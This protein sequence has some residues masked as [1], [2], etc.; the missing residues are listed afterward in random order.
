M[1]VK[2]GK[3]QS[4][5][6][7]WKLLVPLLLFTFYSVWLF[8][9][10]KRSASD[11][12]VE[13][14]QTYKK[15]QDKLDQ[16]REEKKS[17]L[18]RSAILE[19]SSQVDRQ[20]NIGVRNEV[21]ALQDELHEARKELELYRGIISPGDVKPGLR[22]QRLEI[23]TTQEEGLYAFELTLTQV[24]RSGRSAQG[25]IGLEVL[26]EDNGHN[27]VIVFNKLADNGTRPL[28]FKFRYFQHFQG[29]LRLPRD[30]K[31]RRIQVKLTPQGKK[32]P[33]AVEKEFAWPY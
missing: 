13:L 12:L 25:Q 15:L 4:G 29:E 26:G 27:A 3:F 9:Y 8:D 28:K 11:E 33:P 20:A 22:V 30:F 31:P 14:R 1:S 2:T 23:E 24:K 16:T 6:I 18:E 19:R 21:V 7:A 17:L 10:G 5:R 32:Q